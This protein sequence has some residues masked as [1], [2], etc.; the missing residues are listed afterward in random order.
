MLKAV[1]ETE[2]PRPPHLQHL[3]CGL[4]GSLLGCLDG[5]E[6]PELL[7]D[8]LEDTLADLVVLLQEL[9]GV[10]AALPKAF[11]AVGE[12]GAALLD[13]LVLDAHVQHAPLAGDPLSVHHVELHR[14]ERRGHLVLDDLNPRLVAHRVVADLQ[15]PD[16]P[17]V[18]P[19]A[20]IELQR[21]PPRRRLRRAKH[22]PYLLPEL[23]DENS[24]RI[25]TSERAR[26][27]PQSLAH[28]PSLK[29]HMRVAHLSLDLSPRYKG[30]DRVYNDDVEG[31]ASDEG[32]RYLQGLLAVIRLGEVEVFEIHPDG[33]GVGRVEG[34]LGVDE[35]GEAS[36]SLRLGDDVQGEGRLAARFGTEDLDDPAPGDPADPEGYVEGQ[37]AGR[38]GGDP[39]SVLV[40]HAHDR[41]LPELPLYLGDGGVYSLALIQCVLQITNVCRL[42]GIVSRP[43]VLECPKDLT[44]QNALDGFFARLERFSYQLRV[45][46]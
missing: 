8:L 32:I 39:L 7:V 18:Q 15:R 35:G 4:L 30:G 22:H 21:P 40:A 46:K 31:A 19:H 11:V 33:L 34:V 1:E 29:P 44:S 23:V 13:H 36:C 42:I 14:L 41:T 12:P 3:S 37:G 9:L 26:E 5:L 10:L 20:G 38:N 2:P 27:L 24:G 28:E 17:D 6:Q 16:A 43:I 45:G 25:G